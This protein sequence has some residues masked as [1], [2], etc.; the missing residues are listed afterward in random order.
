MS[1]S[2]S[3]IDTTEISSLNLSSFKFNDAK[4]SLKSFSSRNP[5]NL[6]HKK[7]TTIETVYC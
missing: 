1:I 6:V 4:T 2:M 7:L 5:I 3:C